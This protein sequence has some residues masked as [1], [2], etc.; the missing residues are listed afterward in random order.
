MKDGIHLSPV[1]RIEGHL[2]VKLELSQ[3]RVA[4]AQVTGEMFRGFE[5]I[6]RGRH[7]MDAQQITQ[8]ICGVCPVEHGVAS[9]RAQDM[10]YGLEVPSNGR[11][12]RNLIQAAN[13][14]TSHITH[15][16]L[17]CGLDFV[18]VASLL[19]YTGTDRTLLGL[20][21]W[22]KAQLATASANPV[23]P[24]LP[25]WPAGLIEDADLNATVLRHYVEAIAARRT[26]HKL[27]ALFAGKL[28]HAAS[29]VPGGVT[30]HADAS[31]IAHARA[32][33]Q[34]LKAFVEDAYLPDVAAVAGAF[35]EYFKLGRG[36]GNFLAY[37]AFPEKT[38]SFVFKGGTLLDGRLA[39]LNL[40]QIGEDVRHSWFSSGS[41]LHPS[42]GAT[43]AKPGKPG[44][45]SWLK[46]PRYDQQPMEVGALA[47]L[48]IS[49]ESPGGEPFRNLIYKY[50]KILGLAPDALVSVMGRHLARALE[51]QLL[52]ERCEVW[53]DELHPDKPS[54]L[55][56]E[57]PSSCEGHGLTEAARGALGHWLRVEKGKIANYQCVV[58][59]TWNCSPRDDRSIPGP[60]EQAIEGTAIADPASPI[61]AA[62]II[63]SFD[64]CLA[65][66]VH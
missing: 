53:L 11:L 35:P 34:E 61:E 26:G 23:G 39:P 30:E 45:Y 21:D 14:I 10:A 5:N 17:L 37:D 56:F 55:P 60:V 28:P 38:G 2:G 29:L 58:P 64:P 51:S 36:C 12:L 44:A 22:A 33:L 25:Q 62:R 46:A 20:K 13:F 6:L 18:N 54:F 7:P 63:R 42:I 27:G 41:G 9:I 31:K 24:F 47:R 16:Y 43:E 19:S 50:L 48:L 57:V 3:G 66:A 49:A 52:I 15:F 32:L 59:T 65:C 40:A 8:R 1:T 4:T